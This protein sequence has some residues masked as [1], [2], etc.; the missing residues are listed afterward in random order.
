MRAFDLRQS[1]FDLESTP[2]HGRVSFFKYGTTELENIYDENGTP[3]ANPQYTNTI[4]QLDNQVFLKDNADYTIVFDKYVGN[5]DF[6][7]DPDGWLFQYSCADRWLVYELSVESDSL[8]SV[9]TIHDLAMLNPDEVAD[10]DGEKVVALLGYDSVGDKA[11]VYY[12][13]DSESI[14]SDNGGSIIKVQN[15]ST[16]RWL[17]LNTFNSI[18]GLDVRHF[19]VFGADSTSEASDTMSYKIQYASDYAQSIHVPLYF[20]SNGGQLTFYKLNNVNLYGALFAESTRIFGN[21]GTSSTIT[22]MD[23]DTYLDA[24]S[25]ANYKAQFT[26]TGETVKTSWGVDTVNCIFAPTYKLIVDSLV[27]TSN[28]EWSN[29]VAEIF[30]DIENA[31]FDG[32]DIVSVGHLGNRCTFMNCRLTES[33]FKSDVNLNTITVFDNDTI[34]IE[35]WPTTHKWYALVQQLSSSAFDFKGR[36]VDSS[37]ENTNGQYIILRNAYFSGYEISQ[38]NIELEYCNGRAILPTTVQSLSIAGSVDLKFIDSDTTDVTTLAM[39]DSTVKFG[40]NV[41]FGSVSITN[42]VLDDSGIT[43]SI[44]SFD[45]K[46]STISSHLSGGSTFS[47]VDCI[48]N[49]KIMYPSNPTLIR[50]DLYMGVYQTLMS[51]QELGFNIIGCSFWSGEGHVLKSTVPNALVVGQW[52]D[53]FSNIDHHFITIDRTNFDPDEQHHSYKYS[54]NNGPYVLQRDS[55]S[56]SD[57]VYI[58]PDYGAADIYGATQN[59]ALYTAYTIGSG[60]NSAAAL[61]YRGR[62]FANSG[63]VGGTTDSS[64]Y[65]TEFQLFTVGTQNLGD[66]TL[67]MSMTSKKTQSMYIGGA[68]PLSYNELIP[69]QSTPVSLNEVEKLWFSSQSGTL[70]VP[71]GIMFYNA[72]TW[73][74]TSAVGLGL[75]YTT[76]FPGESDW[77]VPVKYQLNA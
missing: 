39:R 9:N 66:V 20:G 60:G 1:Y 54:G 14:D 44:L 22:V 18:D 62:Q 73:R 46:K 35:D 12:Q 64:F 30:E 77:Q 69:F 19:G 37:C 49:G 70:G 63:D 15:I 71:K 59:K 21:T 13:W 76:Q 45:A 16:G 27:N 65:L 23:P 40:H 74:V 56:W 68:I 3:L 53:N 52:I 50:C 33:M 75:L 28:R 58:G 4:G 38:R 42:S 36:V 47:A 51:G 29:I 32:C 17:L 26:I 43:H 57:I 31:Q 6:Q 72:Y 48:F 25:N 41:N 2:L 34:D 55:A 11:T 8:Q 7:T 10:R 24:F 67:T 5:G 61:G